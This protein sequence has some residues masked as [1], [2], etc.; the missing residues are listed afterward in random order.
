MN[1]R[2]TQSERLSHIYPLSIKPP[3]EE[4]G[5][6]KIDGHE[7]CEGFNADAEFIREKGG[8]RGEGRAE[9]FLSYRLTSCRF[10]KF[11]IPRLYHYCKNCGNFTLKQLQKSWKK[12]TKY[13]VLYQS[14]CVIFIRVFFIFNFFY[15]L[16]VT[17]VYGLSMMFQYARTDFHVISSVSYYLWS[18]TVTFFG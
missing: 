10:Y 3:F 8:K 18:A 5:Q 6:T 15:I 9:A 16:H 17:V 13:F 11:C 7:W 4:E 1:R 2:L 14:S 12:S